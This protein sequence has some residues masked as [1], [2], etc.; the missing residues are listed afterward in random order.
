MIVTANLFLHHFED[1]DLKRLLALAASRCDA[2]V[3]CE[4]RRSLFALLA[5]K[6]VWAIG[7]NDVSRHDAAAS[8][9]AGFSGSELTALWPSE[10]WRISEGARFPFSHVFVAVKNA[11]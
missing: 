2:F 4:P 7:A 6:M 3:A 8:V 9:R 5:A 10:G 11:F 1:A